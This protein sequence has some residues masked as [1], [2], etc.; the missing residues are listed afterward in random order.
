MI[1][2]LV[3][4]LSVLALLVIFG[5]RA[6]FV[7]RKDVVEESDAFTEDYEADQGKEKVVKKRLSKDEKAEIERLHRRAIAF[8]KRKEPKEAVKVFVQALAINPDYAD[9]YDIYSAAK[10]ERES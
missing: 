2:Y 4:F 5:H 8:I 3:I 10:R 1:T 6:Y 7:L 9:M